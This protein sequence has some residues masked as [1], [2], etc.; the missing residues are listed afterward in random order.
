VFEIL[1]KYPEAIKRRKQA[2]CYSISACDINAV[3]Q[4]NIWK[5]AQRTWYHNDKNIDPYQPSVDFI[6]CK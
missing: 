6:K 3:I 5:T 4:A 1:S 2:E